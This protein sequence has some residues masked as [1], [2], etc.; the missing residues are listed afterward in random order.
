MKFEELENT[1]HLCIKD[2]FVVDDS[3]I[4]K[5]LLKVSPDELSI[6]KVLRLKRNNYPNLKTYKTILVVGITDDKEMAF[7]LK[8]AASVKEIL[9]DPETSDLYLFIYQNGNISL[10]TCLRIES[11]EQFCRKFILH[12]KETIEHFLERTFLAKL[13]ASTEEVLSTDPLLKAFTEVQ[14]EFDWLTSKEQKR[15]SEILLSGKTGSELIED[16]FKIKTNTYE[17]S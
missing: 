12:P 9:L 3:D 5:I 2:R 14:K 10:E 16:L 15:W 8:W 13:E 6:K 4:F 1:I 11:T 7:P 17:A